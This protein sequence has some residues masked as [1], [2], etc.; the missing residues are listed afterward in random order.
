MSSLWDDDDIV[1]DIP[2]RH[3]TPLADS[4]AE[5]SPRPTKRP[6][7]TLFLPGSDDEDSDQPVAKSKARRPAAVPDK[8]LDFD[9]IFGDI[10]DLDDNIASKP[11]KTINADELERQLQA[12]RRAAQPPLTPHQ[13][14]SSSPVKE[15]PQK[16]KKGKEEDGEKKERRKPLHLNENL[17]AGENGFPQLIKNIKDFKPKGKG[18]EVRRDVRATRPRF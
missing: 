1:E 9:A 17:L 3:K 7:Q 2:K 14:L 15:Q 4:D 12:E 16:G 6:R 11:L 10:D 18:H 13:I 5:D 8:D